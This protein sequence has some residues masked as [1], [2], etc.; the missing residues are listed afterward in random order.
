MNEKFLRILAVILAV[1]FSPLLF[2]SILIGAFSRAIRD[3][4]NE[5]LCD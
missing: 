4:D 2:L 1:I 5:R 3:E